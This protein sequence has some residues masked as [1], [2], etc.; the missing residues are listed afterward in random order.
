MDSHP[1]L[2]AISPDTHVE[3]PRLDQRKNH[4]LSLESPALQVFT[5]LLKTRVYSV[6]PTMQIDTALSYMA[7][8]GVR[9]LFI[10][11]TED[12]LLGLITSYD[13]MGEKPMMYLRKAHERQEYDMNHAHIL[14]EHIMQPVHE[15]TILDYAHLEHTKVRDITELFKT[16]HQRH[17]I[18]LD[19][20]T[21]PLTVR[22]IFSAAHIE[23]ELSIAIEHNQSTPLQTF[24]EIEHVLAH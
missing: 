11:N 6:L 19:R 13:I 1:I 24:S 5:D 20:S 3:L 8:S 9:L 2:S 17:L 22:G 16:I 18:V 7:Q 14:V 21:Q 15:W 23:R 12:K 4:P 10:E